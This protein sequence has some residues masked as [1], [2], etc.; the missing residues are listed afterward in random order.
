[1]MP[2]IEIIT[3]LDKILFDIFLSISIMTLHCYLCDMSKLLEVDLNI[4]WVYMLR[5]MQKCDR[6]P[7]ANWHR[8]HIQKI[9][10]FYFYTAS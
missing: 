5:S 7:Q 4:F 1:M 10:S 8:S 3:P 9:F 6:D 2:E